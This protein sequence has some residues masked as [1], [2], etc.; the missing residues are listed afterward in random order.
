MDSTPTRT[1]F[2]VARRHHDL[3]SYLRERFATDAAVEVILDRRTQSSTVHFGYANR[4]QRPEIEAE[5]ETR[6]HAILTLPLG[7][8]A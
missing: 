2:I 6:S 5:L 4:R 3:Y 1:L 8:A 7:G